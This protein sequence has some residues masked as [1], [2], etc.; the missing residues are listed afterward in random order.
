MKLINIMKL[1]K[2]IIEFAVTVLITIIAN[3]PV[4]CQAQG[5]PNRVLGS[6]WLKKM[7][8]K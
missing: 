6:A 8:L 1:K 2:L 7:N 3:T 4:K 5:Q